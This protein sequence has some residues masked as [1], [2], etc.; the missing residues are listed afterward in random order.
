MTKTISVNLGGQL[1]HIDEEA[2]RL[3][4]TY[5]LAIERQFSNEPD[6]KEILADIELRL[7]EL[8]S[9]KI[10]RSKNVISTDDVNYV[11]SIMGE[12]EAFAQEEEE[13]QQ[14]KRTYQKSYSNKRMFRD[15]DNR[16]LGGV[17]S[18]LGA[19]FDLDPWIFRIIFIVIGFF[20][21]SGLIIYLILWVAIPEALTAAQKLEMRGE[22]IN[23]ENIK[24]AVRNEFENVRQRMG[25]EKSHWRRRK[26]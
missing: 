25:W 21:L 14:Q 5:L 22:P 7:A 2:H 18:G 16:I 1:F 13:S 12:P 4:E 6:K 10:N 11:I 24:N 20:F 26:Y 15:P 17:C 9:E 19:Y 8:F 23:I 3:L